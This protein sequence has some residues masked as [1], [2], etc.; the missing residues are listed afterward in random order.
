M[1]YVHLQ[2]RGGSPG[3]TSLPVRYALHMAGRKRLFMIAHSEFTV[4]LSALPYSACLCTRSTLAS[5]EDLRL[6]GFTPIRR[7]AKGD[8]M[9]CR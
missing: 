2:Y 8:C 3:I 9:Y 6:Y 1:K 4:T 7:H 5:S